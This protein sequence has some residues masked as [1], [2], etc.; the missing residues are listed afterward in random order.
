M[1]VVEAELCY[2]PENLAT[3]LY[4]ELLPDLELEDLPLARARPPGLARR[5]RLLVA[6]KLREVRKLV[7]E[8]KA[9]LERVVFEVRVVVPL[10][11][12]EVEVDFA[13]ARVEEPE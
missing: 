1:R 5:G 11:L 8:R 10:P 6:A 7:V 2:F 12:H 3:K 13:D 9:G 4:L